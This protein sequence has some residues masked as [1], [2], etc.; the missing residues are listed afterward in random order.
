MYHVAPIGTAF[1]NLVFGGVVPT[2]FSPGGSFSPWTSDLKKVLKLLRLYV[3][4]ECPRS[5]IVQVNPNL[6]VFGK[7]FVRL[8]NE[9]NHKCVSLG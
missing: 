5:E 2:S 3:F 6:L 1:A 7:S 9:M 4:D 8:R